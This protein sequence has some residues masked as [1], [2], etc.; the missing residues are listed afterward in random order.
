MKKKRIEQQSRVNAAYA[1]LQLCSQSDKI[2][3]TE[4]MEIEVDSGASNVM[5]QGS[6]IEAE[7]QTNLTMESIEDAHNCTLQIQ[8]DNYK[9]REITSNNSLELKSFSD[10]KVKYYTGLPNRKVLE[11]LLKYIKNDLS[12]IKTLS[13][14]HQMLLTVMRMRLNLHNQDLVYTPL[15][16]LE[17]S[18]MF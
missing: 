8:M 12:E 17:L 14:F 7:S 3:E 1:L 4:F 2:T 10:D 5:K 9:L 15:Q 16:C 11:V 18:T 13:R 6:K